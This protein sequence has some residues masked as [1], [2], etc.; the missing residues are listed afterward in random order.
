[1]YEALWY[2]LCFRVWTFSKSLLVLHIVGYS[3]TSK[4]HY[5]FKISSRW[6]PIIT[7]QADSVVFSCPSLTKKVPCEKNNL[8]FVVSHI[9]SIFGQSVHILKQS[10]VHSWKK[11]L[12]F[13]FNFC[14][15]SIYHNG[16]ISCMDTICNY[17]IVYHSIQCAI[18]QME[19]IYWPRQ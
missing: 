15:F 16:S 8:L 17:G 13:V 3:K 7:C 6:A 9:S 2:S 1:M 11:I 14:Q 12:R 4:I 5:S 19:V 18:Q 10:K